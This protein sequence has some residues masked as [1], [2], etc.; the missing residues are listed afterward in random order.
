MTA[1]RAGGGSIVTTQPVFAADGEHIFVGTSAGAIRA[2][3]PGSTLPVAS[4]SGGHAPSAAVTALALNSANPL[5][6]MSGGS[7]GQLCV[8]D[9]GDG[10]LLRVVPLPG[11]AAQPVCL[12]MLMGPLGGPCGRA[13]VLTRDRVCFRFRRRLLCG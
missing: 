6:L 5:Q 10:S 7:D 3:T 8:W 9:A 11:G 4:L 12:A 2:Y 1:R 13:R